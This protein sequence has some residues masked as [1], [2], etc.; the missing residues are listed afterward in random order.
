M[1]DSSVDI[2]AGVMAAADPAT[3][4]AATSRLQSISAGD[5]GSSFDAQLAEAAQPARVPHVART[6]EK[7]TPEKEFE[8]LFV[9]QMVSE[10]FSGTDE[11][12]GGGFSGDMW[13]SMMSETL[14]KELVA[15][16]DFG[17]SDLIKTNLVRISEEEVA[18]LSGIN[19]LSK[20][21]P[22]TKQD[23]FVSRERDSMLREFLSDILDLP[24]KAQWG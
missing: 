19:D 24:G 2:L 14:A 20:G 11:V 8:A 21:L 18:G 12:F 9:Q 10:L 15:K 13:K 5:A 23:A 22:D 7:L 4:K 17:I 1:L 6:V 3:A 16:Q